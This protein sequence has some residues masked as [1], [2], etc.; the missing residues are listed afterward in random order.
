MHIV[1]G[2]VIYNEGKFLLIQEAQVKC[3]GQWNFPAGHADIGETV[4]EAARREAKEEIGCDT[5]LT[6]ICQIGNYLWPNDSAVT[7]LF[8]ANLLSNDIHPLEGE[9]LDVKWFTWEEIHAMEDQ[10]RTPNLILGAVDAVVNK[11]VMPLDII[12]VTKSDKPRKN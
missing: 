9:I 4:F 3:R 10:I 5:E 2:V 11:Q 8:T 1:A 7:I 12:A 6:G